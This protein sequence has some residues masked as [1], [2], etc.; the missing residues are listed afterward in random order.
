MKYTFDQIV[1]SQDFEHDQEFVKV[2]FVIQVLNQIQKS[3]APCAFTEKLEFIRADIQI[4]NKALG[5]EE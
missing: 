5:G 1:E 3:L 2:E 4:I